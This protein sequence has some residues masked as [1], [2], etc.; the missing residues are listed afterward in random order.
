MRS[1]FSAKS[2]LMAGFLAL[3]TLQQASPVLAQKLEIEEVEG[4]PSAHVCKTCHPRHFDEWRVSNHAYGQLSPFMNNFNKLTHQKTYGSAG[5][6]C[7]RCHSPMSVILGE[8]PN[9]PV[10]LRNTVSI[11]G[12]TCIVCH[13]QIKNHGKTRGEVVVLPGSID[14]KP[15][16]GPFPGVDQDPEKGI[17]QV[18]IGREGL[19][20]H[21][22]VGVQNIREAQFCGQCHDVPVPNGFRLEDLFGEWR[23][24]PAAREGTTCQDCHMGVVQGVKSPRA[25]GQIAVVQ[26]K[27]F[28][29]RTLSDHFF[30]GPDYSVLDIDEFPLRRFEWPVLMD[31]PN[32][33]NW[34]AGVKKKQS[35]GVKLTPLDERKY[36]KY[37]TLVAKSEELLA[38]AKR[39]RHE[40]LKNASVM[41]VNV[42]DTVR[43]GDK[44]PISVTIENK[45]S[46]HSFPAGFNTERQIWLA[47]TV[48]NDKG[49]AVYKSGDLDSGG[50]LRD[51]KSLDVMRGKAAFDFDL[52]NLQSKFKLKTVAG[53]ERSDHFFFPR[54]IDNFMIV[55]PM[56]F[57]SASF[58]GPPPV[59]IQKNGIP[60]L[61]SR[62]AGY[63][64]KAGDSQYY[65]VSVKYNFR[66]FAPSVLVQ[67]DADALVPR[68]QIVEL[69]SKDVRVKVVD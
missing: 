56:P 67:L 12:I 11:E 36:K 45:I 57:P 7:V 17:K 3:A 49:E 47:V 66:N 25:T 55:R 63:K 22:A 27:S 52:F 24:S 35:E 9:T 42:P 14:E 5:T 59:R 61:E 21:K 16:F 32:F 23:N 65:D 4:Y 26:G 38:V 8:D 46:G 37:Q 2:F 34:I 50:D 10:R 48:K 39:K 1:I 51:E 53:T 19:L 69:D 33:D 54:D 13:R 15:L 29:E 30:A 31:D 64:V 58:N 40:L 18:P 41:T 44:L 43:R 20:T 6:F 28:P 60:P 62:T 68:L